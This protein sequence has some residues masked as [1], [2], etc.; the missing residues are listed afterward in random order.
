V[1]YVNVANGIGRVADDQVALLDVPWRDLG[2]LLWER[3]SLAALD[4]AP[5]RRSW[6]LDEMSLRPSIPRPGKVWGVALNYRSHAEETG[7]PVPTE[8]N[9]FIKVTSSVIGPKDPICLPALAPEKVDHE[10]ELAVV[11]GRLGAD[12]PVSDA[13]SYVAGITACNDV[14][15]RDVQRG[16]GNFGLAKSFDTFCPLGGS[17]VTLDEYDDL[18]DLAVSTR[19]NGVV[20]QDARTSDMVFSVSELL[21]WLS[22]RTTLEPGDVVTTGTPAGVGEP[23]GRFLRAGDLVEV[24]VEGVLPLVN[25]VMAPIGTWWPPV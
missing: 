14:T 21:S 8:P 9:V 24:R 23:A 16:T 11:I 18:D 12:I 4:L 22:R 17:L 5:V 2:A 1:Q 6:P 19:V 15:A 20:V 25:R 13:W 3:S 10:C 7:R